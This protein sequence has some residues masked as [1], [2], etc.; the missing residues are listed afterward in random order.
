MIDIQYV[1]RALTTEV[2]SF[3][4]KEVI[5]QDILTIDDNRNIDDEIKKKVKF[6]YNTYKS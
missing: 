5:W 1:A 3:E 4:G 6:I 2:N